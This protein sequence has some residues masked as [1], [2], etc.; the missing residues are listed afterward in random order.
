MLV[1]LAEVT[2]LASAEAT[3][4][5][6]A[7]ITMAMEDVVSVAITTT[8]VRITR[9]TTGPALTEWRSDS[10]VAGAR[11]SK[12][13]RR[14]PGEMANRGT[15]V[16]PGEP[17]PQLTRH[18]SR[19]R[20]TTKDRPTSD[21]LTPS[22]GAGPVLWTQARRACAQGFDECLCHVRLST[23]SDGI[24]AVAA[25]RISAISGLIHCNK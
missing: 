4:R 20:S 3:R 11:L 8:A 5:A 12:S 9:H 22:A 6:W 2:W 10:E 13:W 17:P 25:L 18:H 1:A 24:A 16:L 21:S 19:R 14:S 15:P 23:D 7:E